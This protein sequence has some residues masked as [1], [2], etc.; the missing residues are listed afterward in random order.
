M[1]PE[2][3]ETELTLLRA[4]SDGAVA[5]FVGG[6]VGASLQGME[7][8]ARQLD[9][10]VADRGA[11]DAAA[12]RAGLTREDL[13]STRTDRRIRVHTYSHPA[14]FERQYA[15]TREVDLHGVPVRVQGLEGI[16]DDVDYFCGAYDAQDFFDALAQLPRA[17]AS[18]GVPETNL[19]TLIGGSLRAALD[20]L[21][22]AGY[23]ESSSNRAG[24]YFRY[25]D[26]VD[27]RTGTNSAGVSVY[28]DPARPVIDAIRRA[29]GRG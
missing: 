28:E 5:Y 1:T 19:G 4:L 7:V 29:L 25:Y 21:H 12:L 27:P 22:A 18:A 14:R 20:V 10:F 11:F 23:A 17:A 26:E 9:F 15:L 3:H 24:T 8:S 6:L 13:A 2:I 16:R